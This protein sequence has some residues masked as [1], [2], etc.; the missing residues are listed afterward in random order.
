MRQATKMVRDEIIKKTN[1]LINKLKLADEEGLFVRAQ[2]K[3]IDTNRIKAAY[4]AARRA[5]GMD[6]MRPLALPAAFAILTQVT[7][8]LAQLL[9]G[10][11]LDD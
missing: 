9:D 11:L 8:C 10:N 2:I 3:S 5:R 4:M 7:E 6:K 1:E